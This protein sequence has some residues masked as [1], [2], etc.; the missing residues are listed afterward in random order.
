VSGA[1]SK[2]SLYCTPN[3]SAHSATLAQQ[4]IAVLHTTLFSIRAFVAQQTLAVLQT[5]FS[6]DNSTE[7]QQSIVYFT[8]H[9][10]ADCATLTQQIIAVLHNTLFIRQWHC[11]TANYSYTAHQII[12]QTVPQKHSKLSLYC[13][14]KYSSLS[15][16]ETQQ[17]IAALHATIFSTQCHF[18]T[19]NSLCTAN[20]IIRQTLSQ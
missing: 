20:H 17:S 9:Y 12:Q 19:A 6:A 16:T 2:L 4:T 1:H 13:T 10:C 18:S 11:N 15:V 8:Q 3:F 14:P 5:T 7:A